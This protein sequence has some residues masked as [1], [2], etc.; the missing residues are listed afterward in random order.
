MN[1][2]ITR[3]AQQVAMSFLIRQASLIEPTVSR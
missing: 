1:A 3:D 2:I